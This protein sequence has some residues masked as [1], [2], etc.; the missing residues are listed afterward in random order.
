MIHAKLQSKP[1]GLFPKSA[2]VWRR[3]RLH[4]PLGRRRIWNLIFLSLSREH[5]RVL[6]VDRPTDKFPKI[7]R[8][9]R[10]GGH[11]LELLAFTV[12]RVGDRV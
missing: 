1:S 12:Q 3:D 8:F 5:S 6:P 2:H 7:V 10:N 4:S 9:A 11:L